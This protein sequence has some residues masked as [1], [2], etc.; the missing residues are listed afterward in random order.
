M[1]NSESII[2]GAALVSP[3]KISKKIINYAFSV[4]ILYQ[5]VVA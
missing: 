2:P 3:L 4:Y 1:E 5:I